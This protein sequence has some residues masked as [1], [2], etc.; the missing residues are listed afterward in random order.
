MV[1]RHAGK[2]EPAE[3]PHHK[4]LIP[5]IPPAPAC[6]IELGLPARPA[7]VTLQPQNAPIKNWTFEDGRLKIDVPSFQ[8]HQAIVM[9]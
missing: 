3:A 9:E 2:R 7:S 4:W 8:I 1:N 5:E 6:H